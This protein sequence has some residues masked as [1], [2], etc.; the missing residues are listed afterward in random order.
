MIGHSL[1]ILGSEWMFFIYHATISYRDFFMMYFNCITIM[2]LIYWSQN[3][4]NSFLILAA[5]FAGFATF[6]KLEGT[7]FLGIY[8]VLFCV[9]N[10]P[11]RIFTFKDKLINSAKFFLPSFGICLTYYIYKMWHNVLIEG[12]GIND[13]TK[14][15]FTWEKLS[16]I[17]EILESFFQNLMFSGNWN[18]IWLVALL[19]LI[20]LRGKRRNTEGMLI[21]LSLLLFF[22]LYFFVALLTVN[23]AW[24]AGV[25]STTTLSRLILHFY[26]LSV[27][28]IVLL[29]YSVFSVEGKNTSSLNPTKQALNK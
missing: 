21:L 12:G 8:S 20:Q 23:Y 27:L 24:I 25:K 11:S 19:S 3:K 5:L 7:A 1:N 16:L 22:G 13:K 4:E 17:P 14:L 29:N 6:T 15:D 28:L 26:P 18:I 2:L 9:I 10:F